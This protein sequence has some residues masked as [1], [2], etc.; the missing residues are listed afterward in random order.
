MKTVKDISRQYGLPKSTIISR[1][2]RN[3]L[4]LVKE[5]NYFLINTDQEKIIVNERQNQFIKL[6]KEVPSKSFIWQFSI[7][8]PLLSNYEISL[9]LAIPVEYV[10][11]TL[12]NEVIILDSKMNFKNNY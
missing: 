11:L 10:N 12:N 7:D 1:I 3:N 8:N 6:V 2:L 4:Q 9:C 5:K